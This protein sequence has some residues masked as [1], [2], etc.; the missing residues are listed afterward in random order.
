[1][2]KEANNIGEDFEIKAPKATA[3]SSADSPSSHRTPAWLEQPR[4]HS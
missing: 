1:M 4:P 3:A 2:S